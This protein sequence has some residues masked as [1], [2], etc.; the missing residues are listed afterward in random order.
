MAKADQCSISET[1]SECKGQI[2]VTEQQHG[3]QHYITWNAANRNKRSPVS[4]RSHPILSQSL[5]LEK[6]ADISN[7]ASLVLPFSRPEEEALTLSDGRLPSRK[8]LW[9]LQQSL[10]TRG[11]SHFNFPVSCQWMGLELINVEESQTFGNRRKLQI[12]S[13]STLKYYSS[14]LY[15]YSISIKAKCSFLCIREARNK[16]ILGDTIPV[17]QVLF[18]WQPMFYCYDCTVFIHLMH[19]WE[20]NFNSTLMNL[21]SQ[22]AQE[23]AVAL[24]FNRKKEMEAPWHSM[25]VLKDIQKLA[26]GSDSFSV[27][28]FT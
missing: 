9:L 20:N 2:S 11:K 23:A 28:C 3:S 8:M 13:I 18:L 21:T 5:W 19:F 15:K 4:H 14:F 22:L 27:R 16:F 10:T 12:S 26:F 24:N 6:Q 25:T 1:I 7:S 17:S